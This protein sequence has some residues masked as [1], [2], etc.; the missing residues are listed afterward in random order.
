MI[1]QMDAV[2]EVLGAETN[3]DE[4]IRRYAGHFVHPDDREEYLG[5]M[6]YS[7]LMD[8]LDE[9]HPLLAV[10]YRRIKENEDG[11]FSEYGWVRATI[12]LADSEEGKPTTALYTALDVTDSKQKEEKEHQALKEACE[13]ATRAN[14]S[15]SEFLSRMS[16]DIR[17]PMNAIIGMTAIAGTLS[18]IHISEPTRL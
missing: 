2:G 4:A 3:Y 17:T 18:L 10:E 14:A 15:K 11:S 12:V 8:T 9:E 16:H 5:K 13:A 1:K 6:D 7:N